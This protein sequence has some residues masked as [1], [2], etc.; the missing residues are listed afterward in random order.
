MDRLVSTQVVLVEQQPQPLFQPQQF[1]TQAL[2][3][4]LQVVL[5]MQ[6]AVLTQFLLLA[7][8]EFQLVAVLDTT[9]QQGTELVVLV[10]AVL[11][12]AVAVQ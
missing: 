11:F 2:L 3:L 12:V 6:A 4:R 5:D 7:V 1:L 10:V 9:L 8:Q